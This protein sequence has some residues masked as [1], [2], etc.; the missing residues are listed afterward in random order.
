VADIPDLTRL[1]APKAPPFSIPTWIRPVPVPAGAHRLA[2]GW[3]SFDLVD[4]VQRD[5]TAYSVSRH[6]PD[7]V[8]AMGGDRDGVAA[9]LDRLMAPRPDWA[10][11]SPDRPVIM[12][13]LNVT[14]DSFSDGGRHNAPARAV[15]AGRA[16]IEAGAGIIDIGGES[17]RP[18]A[19]PV[20][21]NQELARVLP[22]IAGLKDAAAAL[23]IDTRHAEVMTRATAAG[24]GII[25]DVNGLRGEGALDAAAASGAAVAIMHMQGTPE[26]MQKDPHYGFAP[27]EIYE[28]LENRIADAEAAGIPRRHIAI[29]PGFGFGKSPS[30]NLSVIG[31]TAMFHGLGV[32]I[33]V[34]ASRKSSIATLSA[35]EPADQRLAG[36]LGLAMAAVAQ[37]CQIL[38]VH[39]VAE[40]RQALAIQMAL[41][42][43]V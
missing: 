38:R 18:G 23:S 19:E 33:L 27:V 2:G 17:T 13:I 34:G 39:D 42:A 11:L 32:P 16:M 31:W 26:T 21:R 4:I 1:A 28:F 6:T 25:N 43:S 7:E 14:P 35:G 5:D 9:V 30:H 12:G 22:P 24:A 20:T 15:A 3:A 10:G 36:S 8:L 41:A 29:D 37:G 40:T